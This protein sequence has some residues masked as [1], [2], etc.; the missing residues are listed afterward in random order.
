[1]AAPL[2]F[3]ALFTHFTRPG[4]ESPF[5]GAAYVGAAVICLGTLGL[6]L[7]QEPRELQSQEK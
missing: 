3:T 1:V 2:V 6:W 4:M 7:Y 5:Y